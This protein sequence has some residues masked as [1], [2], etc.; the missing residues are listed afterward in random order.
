M[1]K[2]SSRFSQ[3]R[4][5]IHL[6]PLPDGRASITFQIEETMCSHDAKQQSN[7]Y[8]DENDSDPDFDDD[9]TDPD[10]EEDYADPD[11]EDDFCDLDFDDDDRDAFDEDWE[12]ADTDDESPEDSDDNLDRVVVYSN[13]SCKECR[14]QNRCTNYLTH[15]ADGILVVHYT[16]GYKPQSPC[17]AAIAECLQQVAM[18]TREGKRS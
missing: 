15:K 14:N 18:G 1:H 11:F 13:R 8:L 7:A 3:K 2:A 10:F 4:E 12:D 16:S 6:M 17:D 9:Y 5:T